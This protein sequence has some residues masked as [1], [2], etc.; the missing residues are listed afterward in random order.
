M[1]GP[2]ALILRHLAL[3]QS[4]EQEIVSEKL[5]RMEATA[6][7]P[8]SK[9]RK[10]V[11]VCVF[12]CNG[13]DTGLVTARSLLG[14]PVMGWKPSPRGLS[15]FHCN[16]CRSSLILGKIQCD[17]QKTQRKKTKVY[18]LIIYF[19]CFSVMSESTDDDLDKCDWSKRCEQ[20]HKI[21]P[22]KLPFPW[23]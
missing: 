5:R 7:F 17:E 9:S 18:S 6:V 13:P 14:N 2:F 19:A 21:A 22:V 4:G 23:T 11:I 20:S 16:N 8:W 12:P 1:F 3:I 10:W 15:G